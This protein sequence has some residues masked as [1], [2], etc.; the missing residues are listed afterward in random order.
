M[1]TP[2]RDNGMIDIYPIKRRNFRETAEQPGM[3]I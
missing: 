3:F 1:L 2:C